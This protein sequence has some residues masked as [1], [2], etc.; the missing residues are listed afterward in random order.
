MSANNNAIKITVGLFIG[1]V[2]VYLAVRNVNIGDMFNALAEANYLYIL[3]AFFVVLLSHYLRALR[4]KYFLAPIKTVNTRSLFSALVIGY[5]ANT[6]VPAH[7]GEFLRA[8][9]L[10][11]KQNISASS[12]FAS[13]VIERII[14]IFSLILLMALVIVIHPFPRWVVQSGYIMLAGTLGLFIMLIGFK[15]FEAKATSLIHFFLKP[16]PKRIGDR[17]QS[18]IFHFRSGLMPLKSVRHYIYVAVLSMAIWFCYGLAFYICF[19]AFDFVE[20]Y[21]LPWY[22]SLVVLVITTISVVVPSSP[23]YVGTYH[24]LCQISLMIFGVPETEALSYATLTHAVNMFPVMLLGLMLAN[25]EGVAIY[26]SA[27]QKAP[28]EKGAEHGA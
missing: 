22:A 13:I 26:R 5:A 15:R 8:F 17:L 7:L 14:D 28:M 19:Q 3:L 2:F 23:G 10:G 16:L 20:A 1:A 4:W 27:A 21:Q 6:I 25:Y 24:Y 9:V 12:T 18:M 11:K